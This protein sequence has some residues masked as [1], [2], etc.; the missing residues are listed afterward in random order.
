GARRAD[1]G[2]RLHGQLLRDGGQHRGLAGGVGVD[3]LHLA[4]VVAGRNGSGAAGRRTDRTGGR[5]RSGRPR[6]AP[7][8]DSP[9]RP[10]RRR[11]AVAAARLPAARPRPGPHRRPRDLSRPSRLVR[12]PAAGLPRAVRRRRPPRTAL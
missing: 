4:G 9:G 6:D 8:G 12:Q 1:V 7:A 11:R 3:D 10:G 2:R 5:P